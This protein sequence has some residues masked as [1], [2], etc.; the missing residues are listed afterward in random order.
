MSK[1]LDDILSEYF[2]PEKLKAAFEA[3]ERQKTDFLQQGEPKVQMGV[4]GISYQTFKKELDLRCQLLSNRL[5]KG[6]YQFYTFRQIEKN[7]P[8]GGK[9]ILSIATIRDVI[10]QK[11]LYDAIYHEIEKDFQVT[12]ILDK[13]SCA[14][15]K[16][17]SA[18]YAA[19]LIHHYIKQGFIFALDADIVKFFDRLS[20]EY[21]FR[22]IESKFGQDTLT[23]KLLKRFIKAGGLPYKNQDGQIYGYRFFHLHKPI[24][25]NQRI[26]R[27][28]GIPQGGV[29]SGMLANLYLHEFDCWVINDLSKKYPLRYVRYADDF[30]ILLKQKEFIPLVH[31]EVAQKLQDIKLELHPD[32]SKTKYVDITQDF[33]EFVGFQFT[34]DHI[35]VKPANILRYHER[36]IKKINK[37]PSYKTGEIPKRRF[38]F[39]IKYVINRKVTGRGERICDVCGGVLGERVKSWMG[40]FAVITDIQQ[41]R[42]LDKLIRKEVSQHFYKKYKLRLKK[43]DFKKAGL[44]SLEQEYYRLRKRKS[45]SCEKSNCSSNQI[46]G[47]NAVHDRDV[48]QTLCCKFIWNFVEKMFKKL[49]AL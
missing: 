29:L 23:S 1:S 21:L 6:T 28:Q 15:R 39:F 37:E 48:R 19:S 24:L 2:Q 30:I 13:V 31:Q 18:P 3:Y 25:N 14:Y 43:S 44:I 33:L 34:L 12:P 36:I 16:G 7:K 8:S 32:E 47:S 49:F 4:D 46:D 35:K 40:F 27:T 5:L 22:I 11:V 42:E 45:C 41:I 17:K 9:R 10:V 20:H 26:I 38:R